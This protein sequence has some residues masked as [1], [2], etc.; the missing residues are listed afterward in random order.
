MP[1]RKEVREVWISKRKWQTF[2]KRIA[3]LER[4]VQSQPTRSIDMESLTH[5][6]REHFQEQ[7]AKNHDLC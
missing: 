6:I 7:I 1:D 2:E 3:D 4:Q 5:Q